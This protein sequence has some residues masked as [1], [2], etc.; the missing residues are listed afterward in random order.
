VLV[1]D[2]AFVAR[3]QADRRL[4]FAQLLAFERFV[5]LEERLELRR[6][7]ADGLARPRLPSG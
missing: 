5:R 4:D 6:Q 2:V 7:V 3:G 1:F